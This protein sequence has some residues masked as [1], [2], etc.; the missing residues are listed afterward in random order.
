MSISELLSAVRALPVDEKRQL[1]RTLIE[2][3]PDNEPEAM[4]K[5]GHVFE[6]YTPEFGPG[7]VAQLAQLLEEDA[8][9]E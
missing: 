4:F 3:L 9:S 2:D 1:T 6:V 8:E 5:E 7:T